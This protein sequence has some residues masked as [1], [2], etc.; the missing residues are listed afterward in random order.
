MA[1]ALLCSAILS[2]HDFSVRLADGQQLY[3]NV[4]DAS[5]NLVELTYPVNITSTKPIFTGKLVVPAT[6]KYNDKVYKVVAVGKKAFVNDV[7]LTEVVLPSGLT[8]ID[9]F[10]FEGC[11]RLRN[12]VFPGNKVKFGSGTF[13]R[14][15]SITNVTL[16]SDWT[17]A[18]MKTFRWSENLREINIPAKLEKVNNLKSLKYLEK[19]TVDANNKNFMSIDGVLYSKTGASLLCCPRQYRGILDVAAG[20]VEIRWGAIADCTRLRTVILPT[21][22]TSL[23]YR[24][25]AKL[26][27][28]ENIVMK[29][30]TPIVTAQ[31][32]DQKMF[33]I[34][35]A[36]PALKLYV[37]KKVK[38]AYQKAIVQTPGNYS[39]VKSSLPDGMDSKRSIVPFEVKATEI[40]SKKNVLP[41]KDISKLKL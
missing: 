24:E 33:L 10:A 13:F 16:G 18:D 5:K 28:L 31:N 29:N 14:C 26:R 20:T 34:T 3:F 7:N 11:T 2:A 6:V 39:E 41:Y 37:P 25:F 32:G 38:S 30:T 17:T 1:M 15:T 36:N 21:T 9:D 23:S 27:N 19:I 4:T 12:V 22:L 40:L 35:V 8:L